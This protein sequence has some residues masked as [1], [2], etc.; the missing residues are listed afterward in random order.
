VIRCQ[1]SR[2]LSTAT[3]TLTLLLQSSHHVTTERRVR[4][5]TPARVKHIRRESFEGATT[6]RKRARAS[7]P[8]RGA[9]AP[10]AVS[11]SIL[12]R[13]R[14]RLQ[15]AGGRREGRVRCESRPRPRDDD[16][17]RQN[18]N[19]EK[20][21][22][23]GVTRERESDVGRGR[24]TFGDGSTNSACTHHMCPRMTCHSCRNS[25]LLSGSSAPVHMLIGYLPPAGPFLFRTKLTNITPGFCFL[26]K[27]ST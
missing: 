25:L 20:E 23:S 11:K 6:L 5:S 1:D 22:E 8:Q 9:I 18:K 13:K 21:S 12:T 3:L 14:A 24:K 26:W 16:S 27:V 17:R 10:R 4:A 15:A 7:S 19:V 2:T